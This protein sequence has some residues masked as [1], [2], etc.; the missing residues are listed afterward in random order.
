MNLRPTTNS[1]Y[2]LLSGQILRG[3]SK[4]VRA[5][6][7]LASGKLILRPSDDAGKAHQA[8]TL[9]RQLAELARFR[10]AAEGGI[11]LL[12]AAAGALEDTTGA[13]AEA[14][15]LLLQGMNG[16]LDD[17]DR[18]TL[19]TAIEGIFDQVLAG[20][21]SR[22]GDRY[23]FGGTRTQEAPFQR[24]AGGVRYVGDA[25]APMVAVG[26]GTRSAIG[27][28]G[29]SLFLLDAYAGVARVGS[30]GLA[31]GASPSQGS[32]YARLV[33]RH[34]A[35]SGAPGSGL[36]LVDG[37]A[38]DT[39]LGSRDLVVDA[40]AGTIRLGAGP[41]VALP[42]PSD[43]AAAEV[44]LVDEHGAELRID[45]RG[46][47]GTSSSTT[48]T[49]SGSISLDGGSFQPIDFG[50]GNLRLV[51]TGGSPVLHLDL[52]GVVRSGEEQL[53]FRGRSSV[54]DVLAA[55][56][57]DL[58][59]PGGLSP[60]QL[61]ERLGV[62]LQE[63]DAHRENVLSGMSGLGA[64]QALLSDTAQRLGGVEFELTA[65]LSGVED[66]DVAQVVLEASRAEQT[67]QLVQMAGAR[68]I[69]NT[70]LDFLR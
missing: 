19:A 25:G 64:R 44:V 43:P 11:P 16:T 8:M 37:G 10:G 57:T 52:T 35:T 45:A 53:S 40:A 42:D 15:E 24:T 50:A 69:Q 14:R 65:L 30:T 3:Q 63:L 9:R 22:F 5:Q 36:A 66:V 59:N 62:H 51:G 61:N 6:E 4:L 48:L 7:Q 68:M 56:A 23:L 18:G 70:L 29:S 34:D 54:F 55:I 38:K 31:L 39:L 41:E 49:G 26:Q 58:R 60:A 32:G 2:S 17:A 1:N 27:S 28:P 33:L 12:Q 46:Y 47:D 20:A 67:L 13:L 21:N